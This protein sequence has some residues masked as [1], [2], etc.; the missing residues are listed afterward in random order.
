MI[1][2]AIVERQPFGGWK[3]SAVGPGTKAGGPSYL[4]A[5]GDWHEAPVAAAA[6]ADAAL[7]RAAKAVSQEDRGWLEAALAT[8]IEAFD[9][10]FGVARDVQALALEQNVLR[11]VPTAVTVRYEGSRPA[12]LVRVVAAGA[13]IGAPDRGV[14]LEKLPEPVRAY[15]ADVGAVHRVEDAAAS[16]RAATFAETGGRI[17]LVA[18]LRADPILEATDGSPNVAIYAGAVTPAG[19]VEM[20]P[21][22]SRA[23]G[24]DHGAPLR[25][26]APL[27]GSGWPGRCLRP[28][29]PLT[30]SGRRGVLR[31]R[32]CRQKRVTSPTKRSTSAVVVSHDVSQRT[33]PV[34][35]FQS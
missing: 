21:V 35:A 3:K 17:R 13:R 30:R 23:G 6:T 27:R 31:A 15:L 22:R 12:E 20:L 33:S 32:Y 10:E 18:R 7:R 2:G 5:L 19:R 9:G 29:G 14:S 16:S 25:Q 11:Y 34:S 28:R 8:D 1:T 4:Y 24:V 26:S